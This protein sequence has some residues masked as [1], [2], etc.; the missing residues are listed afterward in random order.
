M[1]IDTR[2]AKAAPVERDA[3]A[4]HDPAKI[5]VVGKDTK[6]FTDTEYLTVNITDR[7]AISL[8]ELRN[9]FP[10]VEIFRFPH[11][12]IFKKRISLYRLDHKL[13]FK[14]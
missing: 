8:E 11:F 9:R 12:E 4:D 7:K 6:E 2:E 14:K 10:R 1:T 5:S 3:A 13:R